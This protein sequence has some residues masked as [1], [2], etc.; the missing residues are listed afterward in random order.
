MKRFYAAGGR[1][2]M[3]GKKASEETRAKHRA[4][5]ARRR[6]ANNHVVVSVEPWLPQDVYDMT[7]PDAESFVA[8]GVVVHNCL[9]WPHEHTRKEIVGR[10]DPQAADAYF[11]KYDGWDAQTVQEQ[12]LTPLADSE[13]TALPADVKSIMAY[14][15]DASIMR[16]HVAVPGG[17]DIDD[18]DAQLCAKLYPKSGGGGNGG[19]GPTP[20]A[21]KPSARLFPMNFSSPVRQGQLIRFRSPVAIP[22]GNYDVVPA[23]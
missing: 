8:N 14:E 1:S 10:I 13:I 22:A 19:G 6:E 17:L 20:P 3:F 12:V 21:P 4:A 2:G 9:S 5:H 11:L 23:Q 15:L 7:V 18:E 16:D